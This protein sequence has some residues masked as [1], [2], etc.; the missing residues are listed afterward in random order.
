MALKNGG[1]P[2][3]SSRAQTAKPHSSYISFILVQRS[4]EY[5]LLGGCEIAERNGG[6]SS[7]ANW[8]FSEWCF[9]IL[10]ARG[11]QSVRH[12]SCR[13]ANRNLMQ[14][15]SKELK[16]DFRADRCRFDPN[17][18]RFIS[19]QLLTTAPSKPTS[20]R[21]TR[22]YFEWFSMNLQENHTQTLKDS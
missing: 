2:A 1:N 5:F 12:A 4:F 3:S 17:F 8:M 16:L 22:V 7:L 10:T 6:K 18:D 13:L 11:N 9:L 15:P 21:D 20:W 14:R 19:T